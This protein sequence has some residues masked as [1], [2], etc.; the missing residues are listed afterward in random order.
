MQDDVTCFEVTDIVRCS[1]SAWA[2]ESEAR[3]EERGS[4]HPAFNEKRRRRWAKHQSP[5]QALDA[6]RRS[7]VTG[8]AGI[9]LVEGPYEGGRGRQ[10]DR[11]FRAGTTLEARWRPSQKPGFYFP[12]P[13]ISQAGWRGGGQWLYSPCLPTLPS[14]LVVP[15]RRVRQRLHAAALTGQF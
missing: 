8:G 2:T 3:K 10:H 5:R 6:G 9:T 1:V 14:R 11:A 13:E 15:Y 12:D 4:K 7:L